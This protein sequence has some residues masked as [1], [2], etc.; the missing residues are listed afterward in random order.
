MSRIL[1]LHT[2]CG[3]PAT[4]DDT[5]YP[6]HPAAFLTDETFVLTCFTC[7]DEIDNREEL[8]LTEVNVQ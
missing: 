7:L 8:R 4:D 6:E 5:L 1:A 2:V 3:G